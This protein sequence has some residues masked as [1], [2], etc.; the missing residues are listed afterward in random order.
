MSS[1]NNEYIKCGIAVDLNT[2]ALGIFQPKLQNPGRIKNHHPVCWYR[3]IFVVKHTIA[4][5]L[6]PRAYYVHI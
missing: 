1:R 2:C 6:V 3:R 5:D 4:S